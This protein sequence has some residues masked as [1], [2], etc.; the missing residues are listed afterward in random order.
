MK[1][2]SILND[3]I[4]EAAERM[5]VERAIVN[6]DRIRINYLGDE[7]IKAGE[8]DIEPYVLGLSKAGNPIL[9]AYQY[10]GVTDTEQPG[11]KTFRLDK[12]RDWSEL[13]DMPFRT[14]ISDRVRNIPKY[15][16]NGD[17]SMITIYKQA[18]F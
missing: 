7:T 10:R 1:L 6:H 2:Y 12:I 14:P 18:R 9:R 5:E 17:R 11:W 3:I 8:R 16:P 15:N 4:L 13:N